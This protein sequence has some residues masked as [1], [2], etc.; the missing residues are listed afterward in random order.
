MRRARP[1]EVGQNVEIAGVAETVG[2]SDGV[3]SG[4]EEMRGANHP[5]YD[6]EGREVETGP[7][8][9]PFPDDAVHTI[10]HRLFL[11]GR[12]RGILFDL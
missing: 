7:P 10:V 4:L 6:F 5:G 12:L 9:M 3:Q 1:I 11:P 2:L 8:S